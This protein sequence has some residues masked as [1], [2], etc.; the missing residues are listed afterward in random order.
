VLGTL[1]TLSFEAISRRRRERIVL[2]ILLLPVRV[3]ARERS[4]RLP[5]LFNI[6]RF[7]TN[8]FNG[9]S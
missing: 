6:D 3:E 8:S 2:A 7:V 4:R 5:L 1:T 9:I